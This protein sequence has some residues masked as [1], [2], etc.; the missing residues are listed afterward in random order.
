MNKIAVAAITKHGT[1]LARRLYHEGL[2]ADVFYMQKFARGDEDEKGF[3]LFEGSV[4]KQL[5]TWFEQY[6][7]IVLI[8]SLG[9]VVRMISPLLKDKKIDPAVV[10]IDD[11]GDFAISVLSGHLGGANHLTRQVASKL[12]A[13]PVITTASDVQGTIPVDIFGQSFGWTIEDFTHVTRASAAVVNEEP[14]LILQESGEKSWWP[15]AKPLPAQMRVVSSMEEEALQ[16]AH[17]ALVI[18]HRMLSDSDRNKL[19]HIHVVYR[20]KVIHIGIGCNRGTE[21]G[22]IE[23]VIRKTLEKW[24]LSP[25][26]IKKIATIDLKKDEKGLLE[27]CEKNEWPFVYYTPNELNRV[28]IPHPS[29]V[30]YKYTGAYGVS[31]PAAVLSSGNETLLIEK[32]KQGNVTI[33]IAVEEWE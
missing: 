23:A 30:V 7:G 28:S 29:D 14:L 8:I 4:R 13:T 11:N 12:D 16:E 19:P 21:A 9:A 31:E 27:V 10:V 22:E 26:S 2:P 17:C 25:A 24:K 20:P 33:S 1:Q 32:E 6:D 5:P 18:T 3:T 15:S